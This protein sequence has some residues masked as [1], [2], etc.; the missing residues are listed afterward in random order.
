ML[1]LHD[2]DRDGVLNTR[3]LGYWLMENRRLNTRLQSD[4]VFSKLDS[5]GNTRVSYTEWQ[6]NIDHVR[7]SVVGSIYAKDEL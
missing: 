5:D 1:G 7:D 6:R 3:E 4:D 2:T